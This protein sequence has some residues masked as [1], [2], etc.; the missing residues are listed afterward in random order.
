MRSLS[1]LQLENLCVSCDRDV[2]SAAQLVA[3]P[4][5]CPAGIPNMRDHCAPRKTRD[6][7]M[8]CRFACIVAEQHNEPFALIGKPGESVPTVAARLT[9]VA[10]RKEGLVQGDVLAQSTIAGDPICV[11]ALVLRRDFSEIAEQ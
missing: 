11:M 10:K 9:P 3:R 1:T 6:T 5:I 8:R 4:R 2:D 7:H